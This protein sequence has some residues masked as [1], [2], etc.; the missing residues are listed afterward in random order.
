MSKHLFAS[1]K[2]MEDYLSALLTED[3]IPQPQVSTAPEKPKTIAVKVAEKLHDS[4]PENPVAKL[5]EE[6]KN[7]QYEQDF[8]VVEKVPA[9]APV[10]APKVNVDTLT[11]P[12]VNTKLATQTVS[13]EPPKKVTPPEPYRV[14]DFQALYFEVAGLILAV[15][16]TELGGI[17]NLEKMNSLFGKPNWFLGVMV[18]RK[19]KLNVVDTARWV[20][21]DKYDAKLEESLNY[22]YLIMLGDSGWGLACESLVNTITLKQSDVKWRQS[23]GKRPWLAGLVKEKMCALL[24]VE[25]LIDLLEQGLGS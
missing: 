14:G 1:E 19:Q 12:V 15:P 25:Q 16:L 5:F 4:E 22:R 7:R 11:K 21:P 24:N 8:D 9:P 20:M 6:A 13:H 2:V 3:P 17:H 23:E 10:V 18:H